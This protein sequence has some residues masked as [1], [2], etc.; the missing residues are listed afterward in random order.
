MAKRKPKKT[1]RQYA[2]MTDAMVLQARALLTSKRKP[3]TVKGV[4]ALLNVP[5]ATIYY[6]VGSKAALMAAAH[7]R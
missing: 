7:G 4:A 3:M 2:K 1:S 6:R 5:P